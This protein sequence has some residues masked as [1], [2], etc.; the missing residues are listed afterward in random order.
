MQQAKS[1]GEQRL[2]APPAQQ[3]WEHFRLRAG[4]YAMSFWMER[5]DTVKGATL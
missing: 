5:V 2:C 1:G 3:L 4:R